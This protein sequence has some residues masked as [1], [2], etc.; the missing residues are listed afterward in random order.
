MLKIGSLELSTD[1][2]ARKASLSSDELT[3]RVFGRQFKLA[4]DELL[5]S[6]P[7]NTSV[8]LDFPVKTESSFL[9]EVFGNL[10]SERA[11]RQGIHRC[12][13]LRSLVDITQENL[14]MALESRPFK[15][16]PGLRNCVMPVITISGEVQLIGKW[17]GS[18]E[19]TFDLLRRNPELHTRDVASALDISVAAASTRLKSLFDL[20][21]AVRFEEHDEQGLQFVYCWPLS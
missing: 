17:E 6:V 11:A 9:D 2:V 4:L 7:E 20:G 12:L 1:D 15:R 5:A 18:V 10:A 19:E 3:T 13:L 21:L 16:E 8:I 14:A